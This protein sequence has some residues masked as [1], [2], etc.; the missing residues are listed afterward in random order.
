LPINGHLRGRPE[1]GRDDDPR[2]A[3]ERLRCLRARRRLLEHDLV[4]RRALLVLT[5]TLAVV[6]VVLAILGLTG[7]TVVAGLVSALAGTRLGAS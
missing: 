1:P 7:A 5:V 6:A 4:E 2:V 3:E